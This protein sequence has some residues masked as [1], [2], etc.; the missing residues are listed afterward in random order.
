M[1]NATLTPVRYYI[2]T[3]MCRGDAL[4]ANSRISTIVELDQQALQKDDGELRVGEIVIK[5]GNFNWEDPKYHKIFEKK[6]LDKK[7]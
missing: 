4:G 1:F 6:Q 3:I 5:D 7:K 2:M